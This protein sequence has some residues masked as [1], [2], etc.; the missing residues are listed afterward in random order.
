MPLP[1]QKLSRTKTR[2]RKAVY[3]NLKARPLT[4]DSQ[5]KSWKLP[6]FVSLETGIYNGRQILKINPDE[7][8]E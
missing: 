8:N 5:S 2:R 4:F 3:Y 6:H 7:G 1:K